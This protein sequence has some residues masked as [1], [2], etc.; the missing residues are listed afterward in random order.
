VGSDDEHLIGLRVLQ[1]S[2]E[3]FSTMDVSVE[4]LNAKSM[5][6]PNRS[7]TGFSF[8]Y[9]DI[10]RLCGYSGRGVYAEADM[11]VFADITDLWTLPMQNAHLLH[12]PAHPRERRAPQTGVMLLE[13][14]ALQWD[15]QEIVRGLDAQQYSHQELTSE[16][17]FVRRGRAKPLIPYW[18]NSVELYEPGRT[19][20]IHYADT[21]T[22]PWISCAN[23]SSWLW[24]ACCAEAIDNGALDLAEVEDAVERGHVSPEIFDWI[25]RLSGKDDVRMTAALAAPPLD[26]NG[27]EPRAPRGAHRLEEQSN[28]VGTLMPTIDEQV[29]LDRGRRR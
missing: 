12:A 26:P 1:H 20:L 6:V 9:F 2:I 11:L 21:T 3:K 10:P 23:R 25:R 14:K 4:L 27:S 17:A 5:P 16:L 22:H 24:H 29:D 15:M 8:C 28:A 19:A 7:K 18:W 13:C